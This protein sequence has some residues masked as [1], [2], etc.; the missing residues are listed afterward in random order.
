MERKRPQQE[1]YSQSELQ[2]KLTSLLFDFATPFTQKG[3]KLQISEIENDVVGGSQDD[4]LVFTGKLSGELRRWSD[5]LQT[6][7]EIPLFELK[8]ENSGSRSMQRGYGGESDYFYQVDIHQLLDQVEALLRQRRYQEAGGNPHDEQWTI[9]AKSLQEWY[10]ELFFSRKA[11]VDGW[12]KTM[13]SVLETGDAKEGLTPEQAKKA[14][15]VCHLIVEELSSYRGKVGSSRPLVVAAGNSAGIQK[16]IVPPLEEQNLETLLSLPIAKSPDKYVVG[17]KSLVLVANPVDGEESKWGDELVGETGIASKDFNVETVF[18]IGGG[19]KTTDQLRVY[20]DNAL[21]AVQTGKR[22]TIV[23][24]G[25]VGGFSEKETFLNALD[26]FQNDPRYSDLIGP[27]GMPTGGWIEFVHAD[28]RT[29]LLQS[30][31]DNVRGS[32]GSY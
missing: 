10:P 8:S 19:V 5:A 6:F 7:E 14:D 31:A 30:I 28:D 20:L 16:R 12:A 2:S 9:G 22:Y 4:E 11:L 15:Y 24:I 3:W 21:Q 17:N 1:R 23:A 26:A 25:G 29:E 18:L 32:Y 27:R 13:D